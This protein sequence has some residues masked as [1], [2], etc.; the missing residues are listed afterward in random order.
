MDWTDY[1]D[2]KEEE[3]PPK[4]PKPRGRPVKV[5]IYVDAN[6]AG[7]VVTRRSQTG[8]L[9]FVNNAP[10]MWFSKKQNTVEAATFGSEFNAMRVA[11]EMN[12]ALRYKLRM[13]GVQIDGPSNVFCDNDSV[14]KNASLPHSSLQKKHHAITYH[15]VREMAARGAIRV[16]KIAGEN[17]LADIFTKTTIPTPHRLELVQQILW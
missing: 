10:I 6:H 14:V 4:M 3:L 1:Y 17:N 11:V 2:E 7:N 9:I 16:A 8:V 13:F 12:K 15:F 5:T